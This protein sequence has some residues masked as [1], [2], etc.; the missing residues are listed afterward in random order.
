MKLD[1]NQNV[2]NHCAGTYHFM[3]PESGKTSKY[4]GDYSAKKADIWSLGVTLFCFTFKNVPFDGEN[5]L[6]ILAN[7][8]E[9]PFNNT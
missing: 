1:K 3:S 2:K 6:E 4:A 7:I 8:E 9:Q 5:I